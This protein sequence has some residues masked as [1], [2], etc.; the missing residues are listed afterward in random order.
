MGRPRH[1]ASSLPLPPLHQC[2]EPSGLPGVR[3]LR[4]VCVCGRAVLTPLVLDP[5]IIRELSLSG[6]EL[7]NVRGRITIG[8]PATTSSLTIRLLRA[9]DVGTYRPTTVVPTALCGAPSRLRLTL[10][11]LLLLACAVAQLAKDIPKPSRDSVLCSLS[12]VIKEGVDGASADLPPRFVV[13]CVCVC[14]VCV[15]CEVCCV[16]VS[17]CVCV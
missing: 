4:V 5:C 8:S 3:V 14:A 10:F 11:L 16:C 9:P 15:V 6:P 12:F 2:E 17:V 7:V 1:R 13:L